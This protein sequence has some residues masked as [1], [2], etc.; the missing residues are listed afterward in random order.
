MSEKAIHLPGLNGLRAL[1]ALTVL[2]GHVFQKDF[3]DWGIEGMELPLMRFDGVTLFF[4]I[5]GFLVTFLL[6]N[7]MERSGTVSIPKFYMRRVL[8]IWPLYYLFMVVT[9]CV[10]Q[11]WNN[12][13]IWY[14]CFFGA[15]I[16]FAFG[17]GI[18]SIVHYWSIGVEEQFYLFWPWVVKYANRREGKQ[19]GESRMLEYLRKNYLLCVSVLICVTWIIA[20]IVILLVWGHCG[21]YR[22]LAVTRFDCLMIGAIGA[23]LYYQKRT[24]FMKVM[25]NKWLGALAILLL[26][27]SSWTGFVPAPIRHQVLAV[28]SLVAI[29]GQLV[30]CRPLL[31]L[32][33]RLFDS[34][35]KIS[36]GIYIIHPLLIFLL[37][38]LWRKMEVPLGELP[39][40]IIIYVGITVLTY[41]VAWLSYHYF[42]KPF[43]KLKAR[44]AIVQSQ[45]ALKA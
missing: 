27:F 41:V 17:L 36:Y 32:E 29:V 34:V 39:Q 30:P 23:I 45:N 16:P 2:W 31:N 35:G 10:T 14:Y 6:L 37:S 40:V 43:L 13:S 38:S 7:E 18:W 42:E 28:V 15:N 5:S 11:T 44:F 9:L 4:V 21:V 24:W 3:G 20:K 25:Q 12:S 22:F 8:R 33:N 19:V 1:A 26:V